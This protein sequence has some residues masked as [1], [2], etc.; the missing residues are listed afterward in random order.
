MHAR[1]ATLVRVSSLLLALAATSAFADQKVKTKSNIK[2]DRVASTCAQDCEQAGQKWAMDNR[3]TDAEAC[4][5]TSPAFTEGCKAYIKA[6][7]AASPTGA[8]RD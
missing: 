1:H 5:S 3:I 7:Q 6:Q 8:T 4:A 2:N